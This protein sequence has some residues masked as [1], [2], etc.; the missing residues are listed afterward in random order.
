LSFGRIITAMVTPFD[1]NLEIDWDTTARLIDYLIEEQQADG[2]VVCGTTGESPTLS[3][4]EKLRLFAFAVERARGRCKI[5]AGTSSY[6]TAHSIRLSREAE[7]IGVDGLLLV[8]PY[9]NRP[10]QEGLY[11]H[12]RAVAESVSL[13]CMLYN[14][15]K[16][17]SSNISA[18][19][20]ARLAE[21]PNIVATKEASGDLNQISQIIRDTPDDFLLY[22]GDDS[23]LLPILAVGGY[24]I[25]SVSGHV[26]GRSIRRMME[27]FLSGNHGEAARIHRDILDIN[28]GMFICPSPAPVKFALKLHGLDVGGVRLPLVEPSEKEQEYIR[29]LFARSGLMTADA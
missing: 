1:E 15:P 29:S 12:F 3:E 6:D 18:E 7:K 9:Y 22:S 20:T 11:R 2:L 27:A 4:E 16:R 17:T 8:A 23:M 13:P 19:T 5:I 21:I 26:I 10:N 14:V 24:G 25:V 28:N